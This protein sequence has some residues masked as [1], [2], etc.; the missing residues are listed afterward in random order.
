MSHFRS[1]CLLVKLI[2]FF[3]SSVLESC[4]EPLIL[5]L[6]AG[7]E[8]SSSLLKNVLNFKVA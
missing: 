6:R 4:I 1:R 8:R 7:A 2:S 5:L 3:G